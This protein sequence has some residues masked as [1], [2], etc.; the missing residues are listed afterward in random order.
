MASSKTA[1]Y[2]A[3]GANLAIAL[4]KFVAASV[5]GSSAMLS[6]GIHS[7]V[8]TLNE[9]LLLLGLKRSQKPADHKRPFGY[10]REL[11]FWSYIVSLLIFAV[12]GGVS[13]YEGITHI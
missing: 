3:L 1:I 4:T 7:L 10:G 13:F 5:T 8:D 12:G 2:T 9:I 11:Y 6:E